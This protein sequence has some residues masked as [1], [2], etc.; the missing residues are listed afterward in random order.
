MTDI[1]S[2]PA[3]A[4]HIC[5]MWRNKTC[6]A[7]T[8]GQDNINGSVL[9][10]R[11]EQ[12]TQHIYNASLDQCIIAI[13][14]KN[15]ID[16]II[17]FVSS[18]RA[19]CCVAVLDPDWPVSVRQQVLR[20]V[21]PAIL[22]TQC[23]DVDDSCA[24]VPLAPETTEQNF[25]I[26]FTSGSTGP[27]KGFLRNQQSWLASFILDQQE[28]EFTITD[29]FYIPGQLSHSLF[30]YATL[31]GL[32]AGAHIHINRLFRPDHMPEHATVVYGVPTHIMQIVTRTLHP[33]M[34]VRL[35]LSC[36]AYFPRNVLPQLNIAFPEAE[37]CDTYGA[38]EL[39]YVSIWK[40][41]ENPPPESVGRI[42]N[43][44]DVSFKDNGIYVKSPL[45]FDSYLSGDLFT[46]INDT[47]Y[48]DYN[49]YL[50]ITG[51]TDR[52]LVI[53]GCNVH[54]EQIERTLENYD[55]ILRC[56]VIFLNNNLTAVIQEAVSIDDASIKVFLKQHLPVSH[57]P[58]K[59]I[60]VKEW[61]FLRTGKV[62]IQTLIRMYSL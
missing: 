5:R 61:P 51:R 23:P 38:S 58:K 20:D 39:G 4:T 59:Y 8:I 11:I 41:S 12:M 45:T 9:V 42:F 43:G 2:L 57:I 3:I 21:A 14:M 6:P 30:L 60:R 35:I 40:Q 48:L 44:V 24:R 46:C 47:G 29:T 56:I 16:F 54:P 36:G 28:F 62:D 13:C 32:Y 31:R 17:M 22:W 55:K 7:V 49:G 27:V 37:F 34:S 52:M 26:G 53:N 50:Y 25:Y 1:A 33:V 15:S 10:E 19:N 18:I